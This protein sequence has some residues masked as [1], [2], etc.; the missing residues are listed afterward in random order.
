MITPDM[1]RSMRSCDVNCCCASARATISAG[2]P[3]RARHPGS[4]VPSLAVKLDQAGLQ[5]D[6][7][8][9][10]LPSNNKYMYAAVDRATG[11]GR[12]VVTSQHDSK[13]RW[14]WEDKR[15]IEVLQCFQG[16]PSAVKLFHYYEAYPAGEGAPAHG[17]AMVTELLEPLDQDISHVLGLYMHAG[18]I[19]PLAQWS[20][21]LRQLV[22]AVEHLHAN[23][24]IH[25]DIKMESLM[26][27]KNGI[28]KLTD[29]GSARKSGQ[30][31]P[32][33]RAPYMPPEFGLRGTKAA[34]SADVWMIGG[35]MVNLF[36]HEL[37]NLETNTDNFWKA[38]KNGVL[39]ALRASK[40]S[41]TLDKKIT[42]AIDGSMVWDQ[43]KRWTLPQLQQ[44]A[45]SNSR[46][47]GHDN[48]FPM[49][50]GGA[51]AHVIQCAYASQLFHRATSLR[52]RA[53]ALEIT[54]NSSYAGKYLGPHTKLDGTQVGDK[55]VLSI[56]NGNMSILFIDRSEGAVS[57]PR[58][59]DQLS[60]GDW[61]YLR[62]QLLENG[63]GE[64]HEPPSASEKPPEAVE[65]F[66]ELDQFRFP[67]HC[68][69]AALG[70][71]TSDPINQFGGPVCIALRRN[72]GIGLSFILRNTDLLEPDAETVVQ[73][74]DWGLVTRIP[75]RTNGRSRSVLTDA[76]LA[77]LFDEKA[78][79]KRL[80]LDLEE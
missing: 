72:F 48:E 43:S 24:W 77:P 4:I 78:Y 36:A 5:V 26:I 61:V 33:Q 8:P 66:L 34:P 71:G 68:H 67:D 42:E 1:A 7:A 45:D 62:E 6:G 10:D 35:I 31:P 13:G 58:V 49:V 9:L 74:G 47:N 27:V 16:H 40:S 3:L 51:T 2:S 28:L 55:Q 11:G 32:P 44:W 70:A 76:L 64:S 50:P 30:E 59:Q 22:A 63:T 80:G 52:M 18:Q 69:G 38:S 15:E 53:L 39:G 73:E 14:V 57:I 12:T 41:L 25:C 19:M 23:G 21:Y 79:R 65:V 29:L 60:V 54:K 17:P 56:G 46:T 75:D 37:V 20:H